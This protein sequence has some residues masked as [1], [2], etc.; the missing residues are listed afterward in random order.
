MSV[1]P[2]I[3]LFCDIMRVEVSCFTLGPESDELCQPKD[4]VVLQSVAASQLPRKVWEKAG[5]SLLPGEQ[6]SP[7]QVRHLVPAA[8]S[9]KAGVKKGQ[10]SSK[11]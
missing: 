7:G 11:Q 9:S 3:S 8:A 1:T 4:V 2:G 6:N 5:S 10:L